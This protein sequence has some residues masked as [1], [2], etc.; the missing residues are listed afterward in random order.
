MFIWL[1]LEIGDRKLDE[2]DKKLKSIVDEY[3]LSMGGCFFND[4]IP[5]SVVDESETQ[6]IENALKNHLFHPH[7]LLSIYDDLSDFNK[8]ELFRRIIEAFNFKLNEK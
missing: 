6:Q 2:E 1:Q 3:K 4:T 8:R 7:E 5:E